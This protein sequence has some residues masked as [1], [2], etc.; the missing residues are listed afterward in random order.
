MKKSALIALIAITAV[1]PASL[2]ASSGGTKPL[3]GTYPIVLSHGLLGWGEDSGGIINIVNY[4]GGMDDYLRSQGAVVY[5]PSKSAANSN[6]IRARQ[7]KDKIN[8]FMASNGAAKVHIMGHSQG[9]LDSR[10]MIANL[11]M[12]SKVSTLTTISTPH[13]G[14]PIADI[15]SAVIPDWLKP[16]VATVLQ[17]LVK[18]IWS[19]SEQDALA[20]MASLTVEGL[21]AFNSYTPNAYGVKYFSH[22]SHVTFPDLIQHPLMGL[23]APAC[24][25]GAIFRGMDYRNDGLVTLDSAKWGTWKGEPYWG[26][27]LG[28]DHLQ[29]TNTL[30]SGQLWFDVKG[31][32]LN[33]AKNAKNNQ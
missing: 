15:I 14:S 13:R 21:A 25:A 4:W 2:F 10:Y 32:F 7:L 26:L 1:F 11:G 22:G 24:A 23:L 5:A 33:M 17:G 12:S 30:W 9:G 6:E 8:Y 28:L 20:A 16:F 31:F 19:G 27:S 3:A 29:I 18:L